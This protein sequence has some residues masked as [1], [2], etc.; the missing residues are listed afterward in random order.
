M[1]PDVF[2]NTIVGYCFAIFG[3]GEFVRTMKASGSEEDVRAIRRRVLLI[4]LLTL[5]P[6]A[7]FF[8][9]PT[10]SDWGQFGFLFSAVTN[11]AFEVAMLVR[12]TKLTRH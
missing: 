6:A 7:L 3:A 4:G 2:L 5:V 11:L 10:L 8:R 9:Q 1:T 12:M